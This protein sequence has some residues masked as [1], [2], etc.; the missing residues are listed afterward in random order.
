MSQTDL[1]KYQKHIK[2]RLQEIAPVF[3]KATVGDFSGN[4]TIPKQQDELTEF[5]VGVQIILET[6]REKVDQLET[7]VKEQRAAN[8]MIAREKARIEAILNSLG[9]GLITIDRSGYVTFTN[10]PA[11]DLLGEGAKIMGQNGIG[12]FNIEDETGKPIPESQHPI[13]L[14]LNRS[15]QFSVALNKG[16]AYYLRLPDNIQR[17]V[18]FT[19]TP[20]AIKRTVYGAVIAFRDITKESNADRTKSEIISIA[21]HQLRTPL[22]AIRWYTKEL[23]K[24]RKKLPEEKR[25]SYLN[26]I[27]ESNQRMIDLVESLLNVSRIDLGTLAFV[28]ELISVKKVVTAIVSEARVPIEAKKLSI[29]TDIPANLPPAFI[30]RNAV[31]I[32]LQ[33]LINNAVDYSY[34]G[35]TV[36]IRARYQQPYIMVSV[37]DEGVGIPARQQSQIFTKLFRADNAPRMST[38]GS[39]IGLYVT[40][41]MIEQSGGKIWLESTEN[42]GTKMHVTIPTA[43]TKE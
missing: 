22:T 41:A 28:P 1:Q 4:V 30:D 31:H 24:A 2:T 12:L 17:R 9:D 26:Q 25:V 35:K 18:A 5:F 43:Q 15:T 42:A 29:Q 16:P 14:A 27:S 3:A 19:I 39:G 37:I 10:Q 33:N 21:S 38:H 34:D 8:N 36:H 40:K 23:L 6:I 11:A 7:S 20:I 32:V 13:S